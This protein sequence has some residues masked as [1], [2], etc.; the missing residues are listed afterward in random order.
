[1]K[2]LSKLY[3]L[4]YKILQEYKKAMEFFVPSIFTDL[5]EK[6]SKNAHLSRSQFW[7]RPTLFLSRNPSEQVQ[8]CD[9]TKLLH[10]IECSG[11]TF[12]VIRL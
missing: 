7:G 8:L 5:K 4:K 6:W 1:M 12:I 3:F 2:R 11:Q 9:P 10:A